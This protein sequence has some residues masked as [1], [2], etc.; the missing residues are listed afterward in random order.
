MTIGKKLTLCFAASFAAALALGG[1]YQYSVGTLSA[2]LDTAIRQ[3]SLKT[4]LLGNLKADVQSVRFC[5]RG[6]LLYSTVNNEAKVKENQQLYRKALESALAG[7]ARLRLLLVTEEEKRLERRISDGLQSY[8]SILTNVN[9]LIREGKLSEA[10]AYNA[11]KT[12]LVGKQLIADAEEILDRQRKLN[13]LSLAR[14]EQL[15]WISRL[16]ALGLLFACAL[17][18]CVVAL[19]VTRLTKDLKHAAES[20]QEGS[21]RIAGAAS[22]VSSAST[23]LAG[24]ASEQ[25]GSVEETSAAADEIAAMARRNVEGAHHAVERITHFEAVSTKAETAVASMAESMKEI[26]V[27]G[28]KISKV[29]NVIDDIAFQTNILALNAAVEAARAGESGAG[30]SVVAQEVRSLAQR[31]AAA[32]KETTVLIESS[33]KSSREGSTRLAALTSTFGESKSLISG[34]RDGS[35]DVVSGTNEQSTGIAQ[36]TEALLQMARISDQTAAQS[37]DTAT[38]GAELKREASELQEC[39]TVLCHMVGSSAAK[40]ARR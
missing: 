25:A 11:E 36:I 14:A 17:V 22:T 39:A 5:N 33:V 31:C 23:W 10:I 20:I 7:A 21:E 29:I 12:G 40:G 24:A 38:A 37:H 2:E 30:F 4:E 19:I 32:A 18:G 16:T 15:V 27:S 35:R 28:E 13:E 34:V 6:V 3:G 8:D 9:G 26:A 1:A